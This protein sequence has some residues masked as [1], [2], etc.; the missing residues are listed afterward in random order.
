MTF[1]RADGDLQR[2]SKGRG[3]PGARQ[4]P[5]G[6]R[7]TPC[8]ASDAPAG[9]PESAVPRFALTDS[10][11]APSA[12]AALA[13]RV[14]DVPGDQ[15]APGKFRKRGRGNGAGRRA[16]TASACALRAACW[17][18]VT[19]PGVAGAAPN[20]APSSAERAQWAR[21]ERRVGGA[22]PAAG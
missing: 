11:L 3:G 13:R 18:R 10:A 6:R 20:S 12:T 1:S 15:S 21:A 17:E 19:R 16:L 5:I 8:A 22:A 4:E 2:G 14:T 7:Q 9:Q